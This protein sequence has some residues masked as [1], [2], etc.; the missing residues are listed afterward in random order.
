MTTGK[1]ITEFTQLSDIADQD[2]LLT[3][4]VSDTTSSS[5]GTTKNVL[6]SSLKS[7]VTSGLNT[8]NWDTAYG[9]GNHATAGY[10]TDFSETDPV[11]TAH[12]AS[13]ITATK[14][15]QWNTA[16]GWGN[17]AVQGYLQSIAA[18]SIGA[19][20][21]VAINSSTLVADQVIKWNGTSW[22][23]GTGGGGGTTINELNDVGDVLVADAS[24]TN[25]QILRYDS[26]IEKWKNT[27]LV[28]IGLSDIS[29]TSTGAP[30]NNTRLEYDSSLGQF[31]YYP[32]DLSSYVSTLGSV[33]GH[34]DVNVTSTSPTSGQALVWDTS[35]SNW[36]PGNIV[37]GGGTILPSGTT[38]GDAIVW[39]GGAWRVGPNIGGYSYGSYSDPYFDNVSLLLNAEPR[40]GGTS[41]PLVYQAIDRSN[42]GMRLGGTIVASRDRKK[43]GVAS[44]YF[45]NT[46]DITSYDFGGDTRNAFDFAS[47]DLTIET[48][49]SIDDLDKFSASCIFE[50]TKSDY[51]GRVLEFF[52]NCSDKKL[53]FQ[54]ENNA[55]IETSATNIQN[56]VWFHVALV[57]KSGVLYIFKDGVKLLEQSFTNYFDEASSFRIGG[58]SFDGAGHDLDG[59]LDDF[60]VTKGVGRYDNTFT[61]PSSA[62]P[63]GVDPNWDNVQLLLDCQETSSL[64]A[65][66]RDRS[67]SDRLVETSALF[68]SSLGGAFIGDLVGNRAMVYPA[69]AD[70]FARV[71]TVD[72]DINL[73]ARD[74][75]IDARIYFDTITDHDEQ[76]L[77]SGTLTSWDTTTNLITY[78]FYLDLKSAQQTFNLSYGGSIYSINI[79]VS[80]PIVDDVG[81]HIAITRL[82]NTLEFWIDGQSAGTVV[83]P[84]GVDLHGGGAMLI[85]NSTNSSERALGNRHIDG[86]MSWF[87]ITTDVIRYV[88]GNTYSPVFLPPELGEGSLTTGA[89]KYI[90]LDTL[91][92]AAASAADFSAFKTALAA[93]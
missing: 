55:V 22:V 77:L 87:R 84:S 29:V 74:F 58:R 23:N 48:W 9:W 81:Y 35:S 67:D 40:E 93:L 80:A 16:Y 44:F 38:D 82:S 70:S 79:P 5:S 68:A 53:C 33:G 12:V 50:L 72:N 3:V 78:K 90:S 19:L 59:Y 75:T 7:N 76:I 8:S 51:S 91:K 24:L 27:D 57:R 37:A 46:G 42:N 56:D 85:G 47:G 65:G 39:A 31:T 62:F 1:K 69:D 15:G 10:Q 60:R 71:V 89:E 73:R 41:T 4:D 86:R 26:S 13:D 28:S 64:G 49:V 32:P 92:T 54:Y 88:N 2:V 21:D 18:I 34:T 83:M 63:L 20:N 14:I 43:N 52:I 36:V 45:G 30:S 66:F 6:F 17:H 61:P 25:D 11:F